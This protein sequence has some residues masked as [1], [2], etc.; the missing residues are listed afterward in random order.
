MD[1]ENLP[2][3]IIEQYLQKKIQEPI[4]NLSVSKLG[5]GCL[6]TGYAL[7]FQQSGQSKRLI[8]KSLFTQ[9]LGMDHFSDRAGSLLLA[10]SHYHKIPQHNLSKDVCALTQKEIISIGNTKECFI[11][12]EEAQGQDLFEMFESMSSQEQLDSLQQRRIIQLATYLANLHQEKSEQSN[13]KQQSLYARSV[14]SVVGGN[15]SVMS[16]ID[17]YPR[18]PPFISQD[19]IHQ[20]TQSTLKFW[21]KF[22]HHGNRLSHVH[23]DFHPGNI[24][25]QDD[26]N[27]T[28]LDRSGQTYAE[29][30]DD[31]TA[32]SINFIFYALA[33]RGSLSGA[34]K[35]GFE[36]FWQTYLEITQDHQIKQLAPPFFALRILVI[37][38]PA[39]YQDDFFK[40]NPTTTRRR[41]VQFAQRLCDKGE[42]EPEKIN[43]LLL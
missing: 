2:A 27:F 13:Q 9:N 6:G 34:L 16:I 14:R 37:C 25:Y 31:L 24:W 42:L 11:L 43:E 20:L 23:G 21:T 7:D 17:M 28:I 41:L 40:N 8:L 5:A 4:T 19:E 32:F 39:F 15:T 35:Q 10:H 1:I 38:N 30:A 3:A 36:L 12:L 33:K 29:P 26:N 18:N 22:R